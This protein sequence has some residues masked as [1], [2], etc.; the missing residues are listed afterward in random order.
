MVSIYGEVFGYDFKIKSYDRF[1]SYT[2]DAALNVAFHLAL[3]C[4]PKMH[5]AVTRIDMLKMYSSKI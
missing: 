3:R 1:L 5:L 4:L 2:D